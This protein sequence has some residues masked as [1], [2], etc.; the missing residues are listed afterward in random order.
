MLILPTP[1]KR[2]SL[3]PTVTARNRER[4]PASPTTIY[5]VKLFDTTSR[6]GEYKGRIQINPT[7]TGT[8]TVDTKDI[9]YDMSTGE[10][11]IVYVVNPAEIGSG[12]HALNTDGSVI[13]SVSPLSYADDGKPIT[14]LLG[15]GGSDVP[16]L[17]TTAIPDG[18]NKRWVYGA[19]KA[20]KTAAG[21]GGWVYSTTDTA[22]YAL[23]NSAEDMNGATGLFGN[24][25]NSANLTG[26]FAVQPIPTGRLVWATLYESEWWFDSANGVDGGC[27]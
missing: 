17:I 7:K 8:T 20:E 18:T 15:T 16:F 10:D 25:I 19:K 9:G 11:S 23:Y 12:G 4:R 26:S 2:E 1:R 14:I 21:Y 13:V 22:A 6:G 5:Q 27:S 3:P 24:G